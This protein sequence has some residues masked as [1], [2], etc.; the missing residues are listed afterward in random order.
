LDRQ[1]LY[2]GGAEVRLHAPAYGTVT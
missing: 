1:M 2:K